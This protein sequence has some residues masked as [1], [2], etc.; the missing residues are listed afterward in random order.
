MRYVPY[1]DLD[2]IPHVVVDGAPRADTLLTLSHWPHSGTPAALRD[3]LS[4]QIA[5]HYLDRPEHHVPADAVSNNHF[6]QDGLASVYTL[7]DPEA[8]RVRRERVIDVAR[9]GDFGTF[10]ER[11]AARAAFALAAL[12]ADADGDPYEVLLP[13]LTEVLDHVEHF[14]DLWA[15]E[16]AHLT[17]SEAALRGG[18][19]TIEELAAVDL[20]VVTVPEHWTPQPAHRFTEV[21]EQAVHPWAVHN[22]TDCLRVLYVQGR[23]YELQY[24]YET[25]VQYASRRTLPRVDLG[26][27]AGALSASEPDGARWTFD[28]VAA[29]APALHLHGAPES[30]IAPERFRALLVEALR[31]GPAAWDPYD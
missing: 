29:L 19:V 17:A 11:D 9:A 5:F 8:A 23:R 2:G 6:D 1:S 4:A 10:H 31:T 3:D 25:W 15:D 22:A 28:G 30:A 24:R 27:L 14:R 13:R 21:H 20:A 18:G 12:G 7:V 16:D 26:S